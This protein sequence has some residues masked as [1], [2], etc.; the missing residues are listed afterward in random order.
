M[1][2]KEAARP[3]NGSGMSTGS[4]DRR[5]EAA[6]R[7]RVLVVEDDE[8]LR[9]LVSEVLES[10]GFDAYQAADDAQALLKL[11]ERAVDAVVLDKNLPGLSGLAILPGIRCLLPDAPGIL[12]SAFGDAAT[13]ARARERGATAFLSKPF[14]LVEL[15]R[16]LHRHTAP[17]AARA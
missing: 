6:A 13:E 15:I 14:R 11:R 7:R 16:L 5:G 17:Q 8:E 4:A 10:H 1:Q 12:I 2:M 3:R 9:G